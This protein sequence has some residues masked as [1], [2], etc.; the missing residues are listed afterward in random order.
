MLGKLRA[1]LSQ[2][3]GTRMVIATLAIAWGLKT[4]QEIVDEQAHR[5]EVM[6]QMEQEFLARAAEF[7]ARAEEF[8]ADDASA[9]ASE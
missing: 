2:V 4:I 5:L 3:G 6:A 1:G 7:N 9:E 8:L